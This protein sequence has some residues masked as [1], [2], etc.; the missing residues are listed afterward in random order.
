M[1]SKT[2]KYAYEVASFCNKMG[3]TK[4][5]V[6]SIVAMHNGGFALFWR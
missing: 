4:E 2:F 1:D 5:R 6:V 3:I